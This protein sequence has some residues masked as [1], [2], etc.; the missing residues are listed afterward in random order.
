MAIARALVMEPVAVLL[1][2]PLANLDARLKRELLLEFRALFAERQ[3]AALYVT[4]DLR[5]GMALADRIVV[6]EQGRVVQEGA[7]ADVIAAPRTEFVRSLV[8]DLSWRGSM[9]D[10]GR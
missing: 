7:V 2:E 4:H 9:A 3:V 8:A 6:L 5:E 1:D 10:H